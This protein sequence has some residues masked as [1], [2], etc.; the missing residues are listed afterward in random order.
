MAWLWRGPVSWSQTADFLL[1]SLVL[2]KSQGDS[3]VRALTPF[4]KMLLSDLFTSQ[5]PHLLVLSL[6][7]LGFNVINFGWGSMN[8]QTIPIINIYWN[9]THM[10]GIL[11]STLYIYIYHMSQLANIL[12]LL[13]MY[14]YCSFHFTE[15][16][17][18]PREMKSH[19]CIHLVINAARVPTQMFWS[20]TP[21]LNH[22]CKHV[23]S[24]FYFLW[25]MWT[26]MGKERALAFFSCCTSVSWAHVTCQPLC[27]ALGVE[28]KRLLLSLE[29]SWW[30]EGARCL[31]FL[32]CFVFLLKDNCF[33]EFVVFCQASAWISHRY[34]YTPLPFDSPSHLPPIPTPLGW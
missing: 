1:C 19:A 22:W 33:T 30:R 12:I 4:R 28:M 7:G 18:R 29:A 32:F 26:V 34:T 16:K 25:G 21:A 15:M 24:C 6:E 31:H 13:L 17:L 8:I 14:H 11:L 23:F 3:F 9:I 20:R 5:R 10:P 2:K 27:P